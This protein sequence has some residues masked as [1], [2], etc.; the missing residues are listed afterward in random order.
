[1]TFIE[2]LRS[3]D[4][5]SRA[6]F[7][8]VVAVITVLLLLSAWGFNLAHSGVGSQLAG[9]AASISTAVNNTNTLQDVNTSFETLNIL[10]EQ[11]RELGEQVQAA[12][13]KT[14]SASAGVQTVFSTPTTEQVSQEFVAPNYGDNPGDVLY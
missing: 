12:Q 1:M 2:Y 13:N 9:S 14:T 6:A 10:S 3:Q 5:K 4:E 8:M 7:A 11:V